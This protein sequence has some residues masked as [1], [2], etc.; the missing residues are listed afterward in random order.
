MVTEISAASLSAN[1]HSGKSYVKNSSVY[2]LA[3]WVNFPSKIEKFELE[4]VG[5]GILG[6]RFCF[7][8]SH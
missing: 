1:F 6:I 3:I 5:M 8:G 4:V 2:F 7:N